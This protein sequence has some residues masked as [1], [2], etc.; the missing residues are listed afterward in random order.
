MTDWQLVELYFNP[1]AERQ[2]ALQRTQKGLPPD[3]QV[4]DR[5]DPN[6]PLPG[7]PAHRARHETA[8][9]KIMG[10]TPEVARQQY[11]EQLAAY[12]AAQTEADK[13]G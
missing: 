4:E 9:V 6:E 7:S 8:L 12:L 5:P 1:A 2:R 10:A 3:F 11:D 13:G